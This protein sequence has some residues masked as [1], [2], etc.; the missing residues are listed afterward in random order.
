M[1]TT[2][3]FSTIAALGLQCD[4]N[5]TISGSPEGGY[6][7]ILMPL[8]DKCG[9]SAA[10]LIPP[11]VLRG[12]ASELDKGF[13]ANTAA[14]LQTT[15]QLLVNMEAYMK[16]QEKALAASKMAK[17]KTAK[18][19]VQKTDKEKKYEEA[20]KKVAELEKQGKYRD[21]W[22]KV[23]DPS[24]YPEHAEALRKKRSELSAHFAPDLFGSAMEQQKAPLPEMQIE[25]DTQEEQ[26]E[27]TLT[28]EE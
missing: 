19:Q 27:E 17:D 11:L 26:E 9:D 3:F 14:P 15:S 7:V 5:M 13:F 10:K 4:V 20:L 21:A 25:C 6:K 2:N 8:T 24:D 18:V 16:Q 1:N 28:E 12:T 23:P 22:M